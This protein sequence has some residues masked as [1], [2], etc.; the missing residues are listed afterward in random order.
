MVRK[1]K[2]NNGQE[3]ARSKPNVAQS[4]VTSGLEEGNGK[5]DLTT[6]FDKSSDLDSALFL[7]NRVIA[8]AVTSIVVSDPNLPDNPIVYHNPAFE[9]LS[10]Y[11]SEEI[12]GRNCRF[13]QGPDTDRNEIAKLRQCIAEGSAYHATLLN[14]RKDGKTFWNDLHVSPVHDASGRLTHFVGVQ[15][16]VSARQQAERERDLLLSQQQRIAETLQR[17]LLLT[18]SDTFTGLEVSTQYEPALS[19]A[20]FGGDFFDVFAVDD[21]H[22]AL[23]VGDVTG[24]GLDAAQHTAEIKY[25]AR[26]LLREFGDPRPALVRLNNFLMDAQRL[27]ARDN[28][29]LVC[30]TLAVVNTETGET[31]ITSAGMEPPLVLRADGGMEEIEV[32]G[33]LLGM[34]RDAVY[35]ETPLTLA[36]DDILLIATDGVTEAR[37]PETRNFFG[38]DG[39]TRTACDLAAKRSPL[40][41]M[42]QQIVAQARQFAKGVQSDDICLML[43]K[44]RPMKTER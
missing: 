38:Y 15:N 37:D 21:Q 29:A 36:P 10:G 11:S 20:Q 5:I 40:P 31:Y 33:M 42:G 34:S 28:Y 14:Y 2:R 43:A 22:I 13:L 35:Q 12:M 7:L 39:L 19:E 41:Q 30:L 17:A 26:V 16:D 24:K 32:G 44:R 18:P 3:D 23:L 27:D 4:G 6:A 9:H 25:A 8:A 1:M